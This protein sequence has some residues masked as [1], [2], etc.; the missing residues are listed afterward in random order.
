MD[1][2]L[3]RTPAPTVEPAAAPSLPDTT[4]AIRAF[5]LAPADPWP[6][7]VPGYDVDEPLHAKDRRQRHHCGRRRAADRARCGGPGRTHGHPGLPPADLDGRMQRDKRQSDRVMVDA[8]D[9]ARQI[10]A[11]LRR[12]CQKPRDGRRG[13]SGA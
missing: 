4:D 3:G 6:R 1:E 2:L 12:G 13:A 11:R 5:T 8:P 10:F 9:L 7:D